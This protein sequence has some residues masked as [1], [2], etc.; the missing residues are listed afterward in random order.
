MSALCCVT[1]LFFNTTIHPSAE[2]TH[3][4]GDFDCIYSFVILLHVGVMPVM[5]LCDSL[6]C[7][8]FQPHVSVK[9]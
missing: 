3:A 8:H 6:L 1:A 7:L 4:V 9:A 2:H 5:P